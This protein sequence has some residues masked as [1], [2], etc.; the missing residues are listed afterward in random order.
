VIVVLGRPELD[1][2]GAL[3]RPA[4]RIA[5]AAAASGARVELVGTVTDDDAGDAAITRLGAARIG[6]AAV[7]RMPTSAEPRLDAADIELGLRYVSEC[8][9]L[10]IADTL[11]GPALAAAID[12]ARYHAAQ[13]I[14]AAPTDEMPDS[15]ALPAEAT[16]LAA[17]DGD[18]V[19]F[20]E[21]VG[22]YAAHL[23]KGAGA[24]DAWREALAATGWEAAPGDARA[25]SGAAL[26]DA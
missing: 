9:V 1:E 19:A 11:D 4:G 18:D 23:D 25:D 2:R 14:V 21:L 3:A 22:R 8:R 10:V 24:A 20:A 17:P 7:L 13:L 15:T 26:L 16:V 5:V 6:H 12:G